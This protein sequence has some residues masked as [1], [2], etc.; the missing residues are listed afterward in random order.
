MQAGSLPFCHPFAVLAMLVNH[1]Y[2]FLFVH[3]PKTSGAA[4]RTYNRLHL[5]PRWWKRYE[6]VGQ[7][8]DPLTAAIADRYR[9]YYKFAIVRN[10][11]TLIASAYRFETQGVS[12][13]KQGQLRT[14]DI[15]L[16]DWLVEK[17]E[18]QEYGPFPRQLQYVSDGGRLLVDY[19]CRQD[20][21][22]QG[23][24]QVLTAIGAEFNPA[25]W[26]KPARHYYGDYDWKSYFTDARTR[27][28]VESLCREDIEYFGWEFPR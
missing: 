28:L 23:M 2:K 9:D 16:Y 11:W 26:Q 7:A 3:I 24:R 21:L 27:E 6:E 25:D 4:F 19:L 12:R 8:H 13:D 22:A 10:S 17:A 14:R 20:D 15:T 1:K 5:S 18:R